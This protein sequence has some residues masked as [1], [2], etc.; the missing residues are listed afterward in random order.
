MKRYWL[1]A[2]IFAL[3][4]AFVFLPGTPFSTIKTITVPSKNP[5]LVMIDPGHG[6]YDP[7]FMD[8][9]LKEA[10]LALAIGKELKAALAE[11][12][13]AALMTR[14][15]DT[16][17]AERGMRGRTAKR[18]DLDRRI[19]LAFEQG[20]T[21]FVSLHANVSALATRGGAEVFYSE[22]LPEAKKL[23]ETVQN[24]LHALPEMSKRDAK[25]AKYYIL[26]N[27]HIPAL[28]VEC[29]YLNLSGDRA[30]LTDPAYQKKLA[31]AIAEGIQAY[32]E[33]N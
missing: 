29:G 9:D 11:K 3:I 10:N 13:I 32:L 30:R 23:A 20:A 16:D 1:Y 7:G 18:T 5:A 25:P 28:I 27:Q 2:A 19:N 15:S 17:F 26:R 8:G 4:L 6:G 22:D 21:M 12:G 24:K 14:E 33:S 31:Q